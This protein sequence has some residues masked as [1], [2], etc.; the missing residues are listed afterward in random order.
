MHYELIDQ[1][2]AFAR[3]ND[4]LFKYYIDSN[5]K[6]YTFKFQDQGKTW[7]YFRSFSQDQLD[8]CNCSI[9]YFVDEIIS[10]L[11]KKVPNL[12]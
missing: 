8:S 2:L 11:K 3:R 7:V 10:T 4:L 9:T 5:P 12:I 1:L 6:V